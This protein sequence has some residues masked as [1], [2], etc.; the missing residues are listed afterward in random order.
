MIR[1]SDTVKKKCR[2]FWTNFLNEMDMEYYYMCFLENKLYAETMK[3]NLSK[4][5]AYVLFA[6]SLHT[7]TLFPLI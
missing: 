7:V 6:L 2:L 3:A 1:K 5:H 4:V